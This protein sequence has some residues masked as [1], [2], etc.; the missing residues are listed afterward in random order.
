MAFSLRPENP[1]KILKTNNLSA[2][3][4]RIRST[5]R[6]RK[7]APN[8]RL[9]NEH[10]LEDRRRSDHFSDT[11]LLSAG[12]CHRHHVDNKNSHANLQFAP[13]KNGVWSYRT[14]YTIV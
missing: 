8:Y 12:R 1:C 11:V 5:N 13:L 3:F 2:F 7:S 6:P 4:C 14:F 9:P 10:L